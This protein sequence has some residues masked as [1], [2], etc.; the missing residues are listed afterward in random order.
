MRSPGIDAL[1]PAKPNIHFAAIDWLQHVRQAH[2]TGAM[3][4]VPQWHD[5]RYL[6]PTPFSTPH[7]VRL[8]RLQANS[9][10]HAAFRDGGSV[11]RARRLCV[12]RQRFLELK[13]Q[14]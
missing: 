12:S 14:S 7:N 3:P 10:L 6:D 5:L 2:R 1:L 11:R 8:L 9:E 13:L 4:E